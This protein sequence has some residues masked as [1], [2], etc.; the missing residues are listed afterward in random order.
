MSNNIYP[1]NLFASNTEDEDRMENNIT[2]PYI[3]YLG[4][5]S[6]QE[7]VRQQTAESIQMYGDEFVYVRRNLINV[8]D[9]LGEDMDNNFT[10]G[11]KFAAYIEN[12][13]DYEGQKDF[14]SEFGL[15]IDDRL[16]LTIEPKLFSHQVDG[17]PPASGDL[18]Y[19]PPGIVTGKQ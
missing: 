10:D 14:Y 17:N 8:D 19:W 7:L 12:F 2:N 18:I 13:E 1:D 4:N 11:W 16:D 3:D 15:T 5:T 6:E 9:I